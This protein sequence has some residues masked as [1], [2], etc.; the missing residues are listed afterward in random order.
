LSPVSD[1]TRDSSGAQNAGEDQADSET[2][3]R[4]SPV[5]PVSGGRDP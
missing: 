4:L 3:S 5:S 2:M 1:E